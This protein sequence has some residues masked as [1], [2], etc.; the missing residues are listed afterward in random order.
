MVFY[1]MS[2]NDLVIVPISSV[3]QVDVLITFHN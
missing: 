3:K 1:G 2:V